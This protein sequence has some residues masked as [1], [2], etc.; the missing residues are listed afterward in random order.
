MFSSCQIQ[1]KITLVHYDYAKWFDDNPI[2]IQ[3]F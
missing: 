1:G 2:M 3:V